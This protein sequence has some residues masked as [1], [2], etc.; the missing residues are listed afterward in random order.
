MS[1]VL[2]HAYFPHVIDSIIGHLDHA[3]LQVAK[4]VSREWRTSAYEREYRHLVVR[5]DLSVWAWHGGEQRCVVRLTDFERLCFDHGHGR[6][7]PEL[8]AWLRLVFGHARVVDFP[9]AD[10]HWAYGQFVYWL[11]CN[12]PRQ[13][14]V[15]RHF[16]ALRNATTAFTY[17]RTRVFFA[18]L[19]EHVDE[20]STLDGGVINLACS[21]KFGLDID[22]PRLLPER[23]TKDAP[24]SANEIV[25]VFSG[26]STPK[27]GNPLAVRGQDG[28]G[29]VASF[30]HQEKAQIIASFVSR[31]WKKNPMIFVGLDRFYGPDEWVH[32]R[33]ALV[34]LR[35]GDAQRD[36]RCATVT[37][38]THEEY[39]RKLGVTTYRLYTAE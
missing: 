35:D 4:L 14:D 17:G 31:R 22:T 28:S 33:D 15:V 16:F 26:V 11:T 27:A 19:G 38:L 13:P 12:V 9:D 25:I 20:L 5:R 39:K 21:S 6:R 36:E 7:Y 18:A 23:S 10:S 30:T 32:V 2:D 8:F 1:P 24:V 34:Q 29:S 3:G 37:A